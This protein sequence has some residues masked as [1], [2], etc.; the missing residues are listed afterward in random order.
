MHN[1]EVVLAIHAIQEYYSTNQA[2]YIYFPDNTWS[3]YVFMYYI[4]IMYLLCEVFLFYRLLIQVTE[5]RKDIA[6]KTALLE[7]EQFKGKR[8]EEDLLAYKRKLDRHKKDNPL[9][10]TIDEVCF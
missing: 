10:T 3:I 9:S 8:K 1:S 5:I 7:S 2:T 4:C 6:E